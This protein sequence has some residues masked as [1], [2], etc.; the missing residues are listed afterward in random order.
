MFAAG[1]RRTVRRMQ[2]ATMRR[3]DCDIFPF[4]RSHRPAAAHRPCLFGAASILAAVTVAP[5]AHAG[6]LRLLAHAVVVEDVITVGDV[7]DLSGFDLKEA[8]QVRDT[9]IGE[10]P[11]A[12]G[13]LGIDL[14]HVRSALPGAGI[15]PARVNV[16]GAMRCTVSR[17][18]ALPSEATSSLLGTVRMNRSADDRRHDSATAKPAPPTGTLRDTVYA[19]FQ[20]FFARFGGRA[21]LVFDHTTEQVLNLSEPTY[22][23]RVR[24]KSE[25]PIGLV[26]IEVDVLSGERI[27]QTV[28]LVVRVEMTRREVTAKRAINQGATI[29]SAD[30][31]LI[32]VSVTRL[33]KLGLTD[34]AQVIGQRCKR[35]LAA[36]SAI[37][38]EALESVPVVAR[39]QLVTIVAVSGGV[40]AISSGAATQD[41]YLGDVIK[42]RASD[43]RRVELEGV[44]VGP[45]K[46]QIGE[47]PLAP[48]SPIRLAEKDGS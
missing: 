9:V 35:F 16:G 44:V 38:P 46:V 6:S 34:P 20:Q 11:A 33:D 24:R 14:A 36:G 32:P 27:L 4:P 19:H 39:G 43:N 25:P 18:A 8:R 10:S 26:Q 30:V 23:F 2:D 15:N 13:V 22:R 5:I 47:R 37:V 21:E 48:A 1:L 41:G 3:K 40:R 29:E 7:C 17:P 42:V 12:G 31:E 28:P 45:G